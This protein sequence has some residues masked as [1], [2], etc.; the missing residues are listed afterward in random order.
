M[1]DDMVE[2]VEPL[3]KG[4]SLKMI[5]RALWD[6]GAAVCD[7]SAI[8]S[9]RYPESIESYINNFGYNL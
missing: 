7:L 6:G 2:I 3:E 8:R 5:H 1:K 4:F 9:R